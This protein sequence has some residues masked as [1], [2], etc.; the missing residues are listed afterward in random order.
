MNPTNAQESVQVYA[1]DTEYRTPPNEDQTAAGVVPLDTLPA[2]W[3]NWLWNTTTKNNNNSKITID[4]LRAEMLSILTSAGIEMSASQ[5]NQIL[6]AIDI[7]RKRFPTTDPVSHDPIPGSVISSSDR[8]SVSVSSST[9]KMVVN[10]LSDWNSN[11]SVKETIEAMDV[12]DP[13]ASGNAISFID[14]IT[15]DD[16]VISAT[17]KSVR[18]ASTSQTGVVQLNDTTNS[19]STT[20]AATANAVKEAYDHYPA[21]ADSITPGIVKSA[22][23]GTTAN[24]DYNVE[25]KNDGT[26]KV[27]VPWTDTSPDWYIHLKVDSGKLYATVTTSSTPPAGYTAGTSGV[28]LPT[29]TPPSHVTSATYLRP[30]NSSSTL[31]TA[32]GSGNITGHS[33]TLS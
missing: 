21:L 15:Q 25:V 2:S 20:Q 5:T 27:N 19:T 24:R 10:A 29:P 28:T 8:N 23:T 12:T 6:N 16:G 13:T 3:W 17:K 14:S 1:S 4:N 32:D 33:L 30:S 7:I 22:T 31:V 18:E 26:M 9:G 11:S